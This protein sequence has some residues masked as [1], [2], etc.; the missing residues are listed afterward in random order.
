MPHSNGV[1]SLYLNNFTKKLAP[2]MKNIK[3]NQVIHQKFFHNIIQ[4][5]HYIHGMELHIPESVNKTT[6][7]KV[8]I[9]LNYDLDII[10][11]EFI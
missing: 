10:H 3:Y 6:S 2:A 1:A 5:N 4:Y 8:K 7:E 11:G 9:S